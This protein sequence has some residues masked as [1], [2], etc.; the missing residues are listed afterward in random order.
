MVEL[1]QTISVSKE[2]ELQEDLVRTF[3]YGCSGDLSP[4]NAFIGGLAA[5][6]VLKVSGRLL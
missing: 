3:S 2:E 5:Q 6:E 4:I 1:A